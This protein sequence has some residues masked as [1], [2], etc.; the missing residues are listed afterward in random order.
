MAN[1][2]LLTNELPPYRKSFFDKIVEYCKSIGCTFH[3][4]TM[5]ELEKG[6]NWNVKELKA[7]YV[8]TMKGWHLSVPFSVHINTEVTKQLKRLAPDVM[9]IGG[10]YMLP[11]VWLALHYARKHGIPCYMWNESH[12]NESRE[13]GSLKLKLREAIRKGI[14]SKY[15]GFWSAGTLSDKLIKQYCRPEAKIHFVPNLIDNNLYDTAVA[16]NTANNS[17]LRKKWN[18]PDGKKVVLIPARL[19]WVKGLH[20]FLPLL[21]EVEGK[22]DIVVLIPGTGNYQAEIEQAI[23]GSSVDI[24]LLGHQHQAS[25]LELYSIADL[26]VLPSL[27]D[28]NPLSCVE[29]L[30]CRLPL[31]VSTLVGNYPEVVSEGVNGYVFDYADPIATKRKISAFINA[32]NEWIAKAKETSYKKAQETYNPNKVV[33]PLIDTILTENNLTAE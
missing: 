19:L 33:K 27:S 21:N 13:Y 17:E 18:I 16:K 4:L 26:F 1:I 30:W 32:D 6:Y 29:A 31:L 9:V 12:M 3:V 23:A 20:K 24:R 11:T 10:S 15:D 28:A 8:T 25:M 2:V 14:Y 22:E 7:P 5:T